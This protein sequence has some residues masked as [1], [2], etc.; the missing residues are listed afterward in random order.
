MSEHHGADRRVAAVIK[1]SV[2][3]GLFDRVLGSAWQAASSSV[4]V[5]MAAGAANAWTGLDTRARGVAI[6]MMLIVAVATHILLTLVTKVPPGWLWLVLPGIFGAVGLLLVA[7]PG[8][9]GVTR[10]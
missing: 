6:G 5:S 4:A 9:R 1:S 8:L 2:V 10:R 3:F 7:A